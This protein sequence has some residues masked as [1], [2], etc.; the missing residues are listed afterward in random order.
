MKK[1]KELQTERP[2]KG[3]VL[4]WEEEIGT[5]EYDVHYWCADQNDHPDPDA[6][7][8][9]EMAAVIAGQ[10]Y[11]QESAP[12]GNGGQALLRRWT[13]YADSPPA[14]G[15]PAGRSLKH[16][17]N[18]S[19]LRRGDAAKCMRCGIFKKLGYDSC[20]RY[21]TQMHGGVGVG[22]GSTKAPQC[23]E[24]SASPENA[25]RIQALSAP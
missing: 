13:V 3:Y 19:R 2:V 21:Y 6:L 24:L 7:T 18:Y 5:P 23:V 14:S 1:Q 16:Q 25:S 10:D 20:T 22:E 15:S 12:D 4:A 8:E 9:Q 11:V 17:W